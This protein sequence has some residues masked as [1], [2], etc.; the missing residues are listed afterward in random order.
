MYIYRVLYGYEKLWN[1]L[2]L[3]KY[4]IF[5]LLFV[6]WLVG[7]KF[8]GCEGFNWNMVWVIYEIEGILLRKFIII[9]G[10]WYWLWVCDVDM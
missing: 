3:W 9:K 5:M 2:V 6:V 8:K 1:F 10:M 7:F 4:V